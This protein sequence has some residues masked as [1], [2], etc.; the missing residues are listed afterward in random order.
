MERERQRKARK[1]REERGWESPEAEEDVTATGL[2]Q[3]R[4][5]PG[6]VPVSDE[7]EES[8]DGEVL[9]GEGEELKEVGGSAFARLMAGAVEQ[10][11]CVSRWF[12]KCPG[13]RQS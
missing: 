11:R 13:W 8:R 12:L 2:L 9:V 1:M 7:S 6:S 10:S 4:A 5:G 3:Q